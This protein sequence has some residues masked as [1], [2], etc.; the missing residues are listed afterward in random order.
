[1]ARQHCPGAVGQVP[2]APLGSWQYG[3]RLPPGGSYGSPAPGGPYGPSA[4]GPC[5]QP[6]PGMFPSGTLGGPY[7]SVA[8]GGPYGQPPLNSYGAQQLG[9]YGQG[10][11]PPNVDAEACSWFQSVES[12]HSDSLSMKEVKQALT[13]LMM[14]NIFDKTKSG[15]INV[16]GFSASWKF[17]QQWKTLFQQYNRDHSEL[18]QA[19][20]QM[21]QP[22]FTQLLVSCYCSHSANPPL[23]LDCFIQVCTQLQVLMEAFREKD[24]ATQGNTQLSFE[25]FVTMT[26]SWML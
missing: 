25:Y 1:M 18:Q 11:V 4:G 19:L 6:N 13:C 12:N 17:I 24:T 14:I 22:Q 23:Q 15:C 5:G 2:G 7:G 26:V 16:Y 8:P 3:S 21:G 20:S 9:S 10:G